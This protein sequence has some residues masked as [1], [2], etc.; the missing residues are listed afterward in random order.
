MQK[1]NRE[2]EELWSGKEKTLI[3]KENPKRADDSDS[4]TSKQTRK[5]RSAR[6]KSKII[7]RLKSDIVESS[8][9][10]D[11]EEIEMSAD[12]TKVIDFEMDNEQESLDNDIS[13]VGENIPKRLAPEK[14]APL[15]IKKRK[16][17]PAFLEARK[18]F[19]QSEMSENEKRPVKRKPSPVRNPS[20]PFP[21]I[22]HVTQLNSDSNSELD[23]IKFKLKSPCKYLPSLDVSKFKNMISLNDSTAKRWMTTLEPAESKVDIEEALNEI[24]SRCSDAR[25]LWKTISQFS[26]LESLKQL[27]K[28]RTSKRKAAIKK[29]VDTDKV[30][31]I[32][33]HDSVWICKYKPMS[34]QEIVGNEQAAAK[35]K[36]WLDKWKLPVVTENGSS[37]D[38]FYSSDCSS[39][40]SSN[41]Y[42]QVAILLGPHGCGKTASVYAVAE[43]LG[44]R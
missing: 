26:K 6:N 14:I 29:T 18:L 33:D 28:G 9:R 1:E 7:K 12:K 22:S 39:N 15:F 23:E 43:E 27:P 17:D 40:Y 42:N 2:S 37:G 8:T 44:Y 36:T 20:L 16:L 31:S 10:K 11:K 25:D 32:D 30:K 19:L 38:E 4:E 13:V 35:L 41:G 5:D 24:E 21:R 3:G 34:T